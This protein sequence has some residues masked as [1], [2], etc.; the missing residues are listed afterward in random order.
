MKGS[1]NKILPR[2]LPVL[3]LED[4]I[5]RAVDIFVVVPSLVLVDVAREQIDAARGSLRK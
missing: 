4:G 5:E 3:W 1:E 2:L